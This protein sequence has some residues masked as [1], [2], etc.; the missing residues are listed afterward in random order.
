MT[1]HQP[2]INLH[3][4]RCRR[5]LMITGRSDIG[6]GPEHVY[7]LSKAIGES[8]TVFI[9]APQEAPYWER[10]QSLGGPGRVLEIP[11]RQ[12]S[13][14]TIGRLAR[15]VHAQEIDIIHAHGRAAGVMG[16]PAALLTGRP[17][18]YTPHGGTP[19]SDLRTLVYAGAEY[20]LSTV[21]AASVAVS[22][23]EAQSLNGLTA[24]RSRIEIIR[25]GVEIPAGVKSAEERLS[26]PLR[27]VHVTRFV[28]QKNSEQLLDIIG[29][30]HETGAAGR[31]EFLILGDGPGR[32][33]F[34]E[35]AAARGLAGY[36]KFTG[37]VRNAGD[38]I[39]RA[40][41]MV[42]T[43]RWEGMP[44]ALLEAMARGVPVIAS[45]VAGNRDAVTSEETGWLYNIGTPRSAA[46]RLVQLADSRELWIA[47]A[48]GARLRAE[49]EFSVK[50]MAETTLRLYSRFQKPGIE[51]GSSINAAFRPAAGCAAPA[52]SEVQ[53]AA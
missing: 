29:G 35:A 25:N 30:L 28:Y 20:L 52:A 11:H 6:G 8:A 53:H 22:R 1:V 41:C 48:N 10:Y 38:Y 45:D 37:A 16:R 40:F 34:E 12:F 14:G 42:S 26:G 3:A 24:R 47:M 4:E 18:I 50:K 15:F 51:A 39:A 2:F 46:Q 7:Q 9:A 33:A 13:L 43:S 32:A 49:R 23:T 21:T 36:L 27:V 17:C 44:L 19:V 31:F 5:V